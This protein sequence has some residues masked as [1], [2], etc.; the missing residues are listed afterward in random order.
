MA[1]D[2]LFAPPTPEEVAGLRDEKDQ[3]EEMFAPPTGEEVI[4]PERAGKET[5]FEGATFGFGGEIA[6][7]AEALGQA[8][9]LTGMGKS[10]MDVGVQK[11]LILEENTL[12]KMLE[13]YRK[14]KGER[15]ALVKRAREQ[16]PGAA[17]TGEIAGGFAVPGGMFAKG[18]GKTATL[19]QKVKQA[20][21][22]GTAGGAL[23]GAGTSEADLTKVMEDPRQAEDFIR[24]VLLGGT[25]GAGTGAILPVGVTAAQ[26]VGQTGKGIGKFVAEKIKE[27]PTIEDFLKARR[28]GLERLPKETVIAEATK[29]GIKPEDMTDEILNEIRREID[30]SYVSGSQAFERLGQEATDFSR[31]ATDRLSEV[32]DELAMVQSEILKRTGKK[33]DL[34]EIAQMMEEKADLMKNIGTLRK[35]DKQELGQIAQDI[36]TEYDLHN[37][38]ATDANQLK[39]VMT[40]LAK[41]SQKG[42]ETAL[43]TPEARAAAGQAGKKITRELY[44]GVEGLEGQNK[45]IEQFNLAM[46]DLGLGKIN[47]RLQSAKE[48]RG[49]RNALGSIV[50][51][52]ARETDQSIVARDA[53]KQI[54]AVLA[55]TNPKARAEIIPKLRDLSQR[56]DLAKKSIGSGSMIGQFLSLGGKTITAGNAL[57][58]VQKTLSDS[59]PASLKTLARWTAE[60]GK[61]V[62]Q[63][64]SRVLLKAADVD[65]RKRQALIFGLLQNPEYR[66]LLGATEEQLTGLMN[67]TAETLDE[68]GENR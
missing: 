35:A 25:I 50:K 11:P 63:E 41:V 28:Y 43:R 26:K 20:T 61:P 51:G 30:P 32:G 6:G 56:L 22:L 23:A 68:H 1:D 7:G 16:Q 44:E 31:T 29:R 12:Q 40:D 66:K 10:E 42:E 27:V 37:M 45:L 39:K 17:M 46:D 21:K 64:V 67:E 59:T 18:L 3:P 9:G 24:D 62:A 65:R 15:E 33:F 19:G 13:A 58:Q 2:S 36:M 57:G 38:S 52:V 47:Q 14:S 4:S 55:K 8:I 60:T 49:L 48:R 34:V 5:F 53:I 54:D